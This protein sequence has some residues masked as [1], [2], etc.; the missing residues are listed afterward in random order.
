MPAVVVHAIPTR[1]PAL[2]LPMVMTRRRPFA[3]IGSGTVDAPRSGM[4]LPGGTMP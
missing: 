4:T 1:V 2:R 3:A